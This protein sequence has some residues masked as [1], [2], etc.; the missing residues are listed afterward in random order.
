MFLVVLNMGI[1]LFLF[2]WATRIKIPTREDGTS[3]HV[4]AHGTLRE[5]VRP[6]PMWWVVM[7]ALA[8]ICGI[9]YLILYPG[10]GS[11]PGLLNWTVE[12]ELQGAVAK[13]QVLLD[14]L[15]ERALA[16][17]P[18]ELA[19]DEQAT[20]VGGRLFQDNCS[21][22]HSAD[23]SGNT[24]VGAPS[25]TGRSWLYGGSD[26]DIL[27]SITHGRAGVMPPWGSLGYGRVQNL[28]HYVRSL[29]GA[30]H[31]PAA[32]AVGAKYFDT[33][34]TCHGA[35]G[36]GNQAMGAPDLTDDDWLYGG[37]L[38]DIR[39]SITD[40]RQGVMPAWG[41][42]LSEAEIRLITAWIRDQG[43]AG[44]GGE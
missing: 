38:E 26:E 7:S 15:L 34:A 1:T 40:G 29:S 3:G 31:E 16:L 14:P 4:W 41:S 33:C 2:I 30:S 24:A 13:N 12:E 32:A 44:A 25:L 11:N 6:L 9:G 17:T 43:K 23:A 5:G 22:C 28:S 27:H 35:D 37:G 19:D 8:F 39:K 18:T 21:V 20:R 10:F 42:R 36:K